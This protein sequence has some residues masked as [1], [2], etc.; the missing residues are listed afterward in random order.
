MKRVAIVVIAFLAMIGIIFYFGDDQTAG[1]ANKVER[2]NGKILGD[3]NFGY[4]TLE[5]KWAPLSDL[6]SPTSVT[7]FNEEN[8]SVIELAS[9]ADYNKLLSSN[10][11]FGK[12]IRTVDDVADF[13]QGYL[14]MIGRGENFK[15]EDG[16]FQQYDAKILKGGFKVELDDNKPY[17]LSAWA[18]SDEEGTLRYVLVES[19]L[20]NA[21]TDAT[22]VIAT[23]RTK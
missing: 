14:K 16:K 23:Y 8:G 20:E 3:E 15:I 13:L 5:G 9:F 11:T 22:D 10:S 4:V 18:F 21:Q 7:Y 19:R 1:S 17:F 12:G 2:K 6:K